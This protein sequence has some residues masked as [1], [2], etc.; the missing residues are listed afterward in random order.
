MKRVLLLSGS[1][2]ILNLIG[3]ILNKELQ[4][5]VPSI[6]DKKMY[7]YKRKHNSTTAIEIK[8]IN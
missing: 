2:K 3:V 7:S 4:A 1:L 8:A 5:V 6:Y